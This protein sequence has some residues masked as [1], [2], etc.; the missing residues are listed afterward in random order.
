MDPM[1]ATPEITRPPRRVV[2]TTEYRLRAKAQAVPGAFYDR[3]A[4]GWVV[5]DPTPRAAAATLKLFPAL[6]NEHP[7]L[8][9][10]RDSLAMDVRPIDYA[11]QYGFEIHA[12]VIERRLAQRYPGAELF[13]FQRIDLGYL[14]EV[15]RTHGAGYLGWERGL[16]KTLGAAAIVENQQLSKVLVVAPNTAK[17][18]VWGDDLA[19]WLPNHEV[20]VLRNPKAQREED[21]ART[22]ELI[23]D[24]IDFV[25]VVHYEAVAV[26]A[27][28]R[29]AN[30]GWKPLGTWDIVISDEAH[31]IKNKKAQ[32]SRQ[33]KRIPTDRKLALSGTILSNHAAELYS[34]LNWLFPE[35]YSNEYRDWDDR[36][37]DYIDGGYGRLAIGVRVERIAELR[38]ELGRFMV[39]RRKEDE[40]DLPPKTHESRRVTLSPAQRKAYDEL[41]QESLTRLDDGSILKAADGLA[42][43]S[44]L[45]QVASG[46]DTVSGELSDSS[47]LDLAVE[48]I[49]DNPDEGFVV[50]SWWVAQ[51]E[52]LAERLA[53]DGIES[54][55]VTGK[56]PAPA[57][58]DYIERYQAGE[59]QVFIG[60]IGTLGES[61]TL[62][63]ANNVIF[64][65]KS[66][67][68]G[69]NDQAED[70]AYRIGQ[71]KNVTVTSIVAADT[72]DETHVEPIL[73]DK[74]ALR[75]L[76]LGGRRS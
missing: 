40:L 48:M 67:N 3:E 33:I 7:W 35:R 74:D 17:Q 68:P 13:G 26:I 24:Q 61:V 46:L 64:I 28:M 75:A 10:V 62:H 12:P 38:D 4:H 16:G 56:V 70:R 31:R 21:L 54:F 73:T 29:S 49:K 14:S 42:L 32:Q 9:E 2:L 57:R 11:S 52:A 22:R 15:I 27:K 41:E 44:R 23:R 59:R 43:L 60:T 19:W 30:N 5:D 58:A 51:A 72:V 18:A 6:G 71:L 65:D 34:Q 1:E 37:I 36:Y 25:L 8:R 50:F 45:R 55:V 20:I 76:I 63:R 66:W 69:D 47:K 39:Y 53:A